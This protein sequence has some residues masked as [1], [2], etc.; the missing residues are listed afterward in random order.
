MIMFKVDYAIWLCK[1]IYSTIAYWGK[2]LAMKLVS[3]L[4]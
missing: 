4:A 3:E 1:E 2:S